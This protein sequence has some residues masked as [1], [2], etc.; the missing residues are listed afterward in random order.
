[1]ELLHTR[2]GYKKIV[3]ELEGMYGTI[4]EVIDSFHRI[5]EL[6]GKPL[7]YSDEAIERVQRD[8]YDY[9][10]RLPEDKKKKI[11]EWNE[12]HRR[13]RVRA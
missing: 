5:N 1:M 9:F 11:V 6:R 12:R 10:A 4:E 8:Y 13:N 7:G 2:V 3:N